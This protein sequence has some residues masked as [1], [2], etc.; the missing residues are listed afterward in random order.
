[1]A[2]SRPSTSPPIRSRHAAA[3][4]SNPLFRTAESGEPDWFRIAD[5][6][7]QAVLEAIPEPLQEAAETV[8][9]LIEES[10]DDRVVSEGF[11]E[12][13]LGLFS[14][15]GAADSDAWPEASEIRLYVDNLVEFAGEDEAVFRQEV[16]VTLLHELGHFLGLDEDDV[17]L[18][19]FAHTNWLRFLRRALPVT[20]A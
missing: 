1:M 4:P 18:R 9:V 19:G 5:E 7:V 6:E 2:R 13:L 17:A 11:G 10:P 20:L 3:S 12:D 14:G 16:R 15:P 8:A